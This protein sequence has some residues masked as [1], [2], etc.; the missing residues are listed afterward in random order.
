MRFGANRQQ[1]SS[2]LLRRHF[3]L[4]N[5]V[6]ASTTRSTAFAS[7]VKSDQR[8]LLV[9]DVDETLLHAAEAEPMTPFDFRCGRYY[10]TLRP[11][12]NK[13]LLACGKAFQ[14]AVWSSSSADYLHAVLE[15]AIPPDTALKFVWSRQRCVQCFDPEWHRQYF[16]K[17][18]KKVK[19][20][21]YD[22]SR[23]LIVDDTPQKGR[24]KLWQCCLRES[25]RRR[26]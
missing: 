14:L 6:S 23:V 11:H 19:R 12:L 15:R 4:A 18:L 3:I 26:S 2:V 5:C 21:G 9:L 16:V 24:A 25:F 10:V 1:G 20:R 17:D 22:L 13:F 8:A 7:Q